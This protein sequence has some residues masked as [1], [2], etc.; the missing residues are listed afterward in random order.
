M[1]MMQLHETPF[2]FF[3]KF[4]KALRFSAV[5][6][7]T[8]RVFQIFVPWNLRLLA[9]NVTW[10]LQGIFKFNLY[11]YLIY[12]SIQRHLSRHMFIL[13]LSDFC[14]SCSY[15]LT[16]SF[17]KNLRAH[18]CKLSILSSDFFIESIHTSGQ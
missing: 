1:Q 12:I 18:L 7:L 2:H 10:F 13:H 17:S 16:Q 5:L 11:L 9:S 6:I 15:E 14:N 8:G 3:I 4:L